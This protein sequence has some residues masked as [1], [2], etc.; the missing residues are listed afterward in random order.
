VACPC[1]GDFFWFF[2]AGHLDFDQVL[3]DGVAEIQIWLV[4]MVFGPRVFASQVLRD[5]LV[6]VMTFVWVVDQWRRVVIEL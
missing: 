4:G 6:L 5:G 2:D 1:D 3:L